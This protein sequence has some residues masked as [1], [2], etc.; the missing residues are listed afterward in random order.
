MGTPGSEARNVRPAKQLTLVASRA[1]SRFFLTF[2][3]K[4]GLY[5]GKV[6]L[7]P[8]GFRRRPGDPHISRG[9]GKG[10]GDMDYNLWGPRDSPPPTS[11]CDQ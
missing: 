8:L 6:S 1:R 5:L 3:I 7:P 9:G 10:V 2:E 4:W 11:L